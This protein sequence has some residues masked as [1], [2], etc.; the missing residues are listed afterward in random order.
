[1]EDAFTNEEFERFVSGANK[2]NGDFRSAF[3]L[4]LFANIEVLTVW[5]VTDFE[6]YTPRIQKLLDTTTRPQ[7]LLADG[8]FSRLKHI[9]ISCMFTASL[10]DLTSFLHL[11]TLKCL[12]ATHVTSRWNIGLPTGNEQ[13][14]GHSFELD[15]LTIDFVDPD[16]DT[17]KS[18][19]RCFVHLRY[20]CFGQKPRTWLS[21]FPA[22]ISP[23][24]VIE[25]LVHVQ[26]SLQELR[27]RDLSCNNSGFVA[28]R[29]D[30]LSSFVV[31]TNLKTPVH[32]LLLG[33]NGASYHHWLSVLP[34]SLEQLQLDDV[35]I[36]EYSK[37]TQDIKSA[38]LDRTR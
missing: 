34:A 3:V 33:D 22:E 11:P 5:R 37:Y 38:V 30:S 6:N 10:N 36:G 25:G 8:H 28:E 20:F 29:F 31:L 27:L 1:M 15:H 23:N 7:R 32:T 9:E 13:I 16:S 17:L 18:F 14:E 21:D 26:H 19:L 4:S 12:K 24:A 2:S 35:G